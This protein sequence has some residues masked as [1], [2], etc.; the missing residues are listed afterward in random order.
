MGPTVKAAEDEY[1]LSLNA[2]LQPLRRRLWI[3]LLVT[4]GLGGGALA[5]SLTQTPM[6]ESSIKI[7]V[8]QERESD[9]S[10][11]VGSDVQGLQQ[12][13]ETMSEGVESRAIAEAVI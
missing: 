7:L 6:Y 2:L 3:I 12:L 11:S 4:V 5:L 13:T 8:S 9:S 10:G 1:D